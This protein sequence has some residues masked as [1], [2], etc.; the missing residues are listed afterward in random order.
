MVITSSTLALDSPVEGR[1]YRRPVARTITIQHLPGCPNLALARAR[2]DEAIR[3]TGASA[4]G[5]VV[6]EVPGPAAAEQVGFNGSPTILVDGVDPF[7]GSAAA[8]SFACRLYPT[9]AG[10]QGAPSL[11]QILEALGTD[12]T[13]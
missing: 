4:P 2:V 5:L 7:A 9:E 3:R 11:E 6:Q 13:H 12:T 1:V 10:P 8:P